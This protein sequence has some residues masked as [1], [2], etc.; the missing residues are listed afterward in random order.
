VLPVRPDELTDEELAAV[1]GGTGPN[2]A[3]DK[4]HDSHYT[5]MDMSK[6]L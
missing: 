3:F 2:L 4:D 6:N 1:A 5:W